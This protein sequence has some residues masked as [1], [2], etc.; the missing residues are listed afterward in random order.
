MVKVR[1]RTVNNLPVRYGPDHP[2]W[3]SDVVRLKHCQRCRR[4]FTIQPGF[5]FRKYCSRKCGPGY[6]WGSGPN[7]PRWTGGLEGRRARGARARSCKEQRDWS[8]AVLARDNHTCQFCGRRGGDLQADHIKPYKDYPDLRW[9]VSNGRTLC[10][11]CHYTTFR[12]QKT[13]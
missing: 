6:K 8:R 12:S 1:R 7:N 2:R 4:E 13:A 11:P 9:D 10:K 5:E 3:R